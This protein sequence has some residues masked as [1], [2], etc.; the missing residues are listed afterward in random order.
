MSDSGAE[1]DDTPRSGLPAAV[2]RA[3]TDPK[4]R[5]LI[6]G[7]I[8]MV[9]LLWAMTAP[10]VPDNP[11]PPVLLRVPDF[12]L[13]DQDGRPR[14]SDQLRSGPWVAAVFFTRCPTVCPR[15]IEDLRSV[16]VDTRVGAPDGRFVCFSADPSH[17]QPEV[18]RAYQAERGLEGERWVLLTGEEAQVRS[19][20]L[21][22]LK[23]GL[24]E[25]GEAPFGI[26][27]ATSLALVDRDLNV[28]GYYRSDDRAEM[29]QLAQDLITLD[30]LSH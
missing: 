27:H 5:A 17:D 22:G 3:L 10:R 18:L 19:T 30:R 4:G 25:D 2:G 9:P 1:P 7:L 24:G 12:E 13:I 29:D 14:G 15:L 23:L 6:V 28:R 16:E 26:F 11:P 20:L 8:A 21:E